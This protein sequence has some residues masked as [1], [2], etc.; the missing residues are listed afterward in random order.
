MVTETVTSDRPPINT[1]YSQVRR[2]RNF[3]I[4]PKVH[5]V[6]ARF[7]HLTICGAGAKGMITGNPGRAKFPC[8]MCNTGAKI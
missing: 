5:T 4:Q 3:R 2:R 8:R 1:R 7:K 6:H